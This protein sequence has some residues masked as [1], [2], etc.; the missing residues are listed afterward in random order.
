MAT[1][2]YLSSGNPLLEALTDDKSSTKYIKINIK[3][4]SGDK[5][6]LLPR[7]PTLPEVTVIAVTKS[8]YNDTDQSLRTP[9][10][11]RYSFHTY[12]S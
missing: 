4:P 7:H 12:Y 11:Q 3:R 5:T 2:L 8:I 1:L 9:A 10:A 6:L